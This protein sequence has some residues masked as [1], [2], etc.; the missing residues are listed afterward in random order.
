MPDRIKTKVSLLLLLS[1]SA[2]LAALSTTDALAENSKGE[3]NDNGA[4]LGGTTVAAYTGA[5]GK[6]VMQSQ[7]LGGEGHE[8]EALQH[9]FSA[10]S[11]AEKL[12]KDH[13]LYSISLRN[14]SDIYFL[15][16]RLDQSKLYA[17]KEIEALRPLG[18]EYQDLVPI[19]LRLTDIAIIQGN[20][21]E[22]ER[23]AKQAKAIRSGSAFN[24]LLKAEIDCRLGILALQAGKEEECRSLRLTAEQEWLDS[25]KAERAADDMGHYGREL[26]R[27][28]GL[29]SSKTKSA[30]LQ[31]AEYWCMRALELSRQTCGP[32][33]GSYAS[34]L[35]KAAFMYQTAGNLEAAASY[36]IQALNLILRVYN[37]KVSTKV[38]FILNGTTRLI[39][40]GKSDQALPFIKAAVPLARE[41]EDDE[42]Y[43]K[44]LSDLSQVARRQGNLADAKEAKEELLQLCTRKKQWREVAILKS[45][46]ESLSKGM[47]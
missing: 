40:L 5:W 19:L 41:L 31:S 43:V 18:P 38:N 8:A 7:K 14:L 45:E 34:A 32:D 3:E 39:N 30:M 23:F 37:W 27:E 9:G 20:V 15:Y 47:K 2:L 29:A 28:I 13:P 25:V 17:N 11:I 26:C 35:E 46:I 4:I 21:K 10:L 44:A 42:L 16:M 1:C 33:S 22:A 6:E 12:G 24:P 36:Q